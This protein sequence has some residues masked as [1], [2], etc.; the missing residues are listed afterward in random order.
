VI[1]KLGC[2]LSVFLMAVGA[3]ASESHP[4][5]NGTYSYS[6]ERI[7]VDGGRIQF[8][9]ISKDAGQASD[10][11]YQYTVLP[12]GRIQP[13]PLT[14]S[15]AVLG[16]GRYDWSWNGKAIVRTNPHTKQSDHFMRAE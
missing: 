5:P 14:S 12:D 7:V 1:E 11:E 6:Q 10:K 4:I 8:H 13:Y 16:T 9:L 2:F 15:D 3:C